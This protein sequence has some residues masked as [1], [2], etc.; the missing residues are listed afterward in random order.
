MAI[1]T[2][3][4]FQPDHGLVIVKLDG[5]LQ[6]AALRV[7][8][9]DRTTIKKVLPGHRIRFDLSCNRQGQVFAV[10]VIPI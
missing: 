7:C 8:G 3:K 4:S 6:E 10:D 1:A 5:R 9:S 2:V